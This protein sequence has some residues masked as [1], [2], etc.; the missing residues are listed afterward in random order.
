MTIRGWVHGVINTHENPPPG[1]QPDRPRVNIEDGT[2]VIARWDGRIN[3]KSDLLFYN[4]GSVRDEFACW[5]VDQAAKH[6]ITGIGWDH[7]YAVRYMA[8]NRTFGGSG[9]HETLDEAMR[10]Y[11]R[12]RGMQAEQ[13]ALF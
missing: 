2:I 7:G 5:V 8:R 11:D 3:G 6:A 1:S 10:H 12:L 4:C 13:P 9:W